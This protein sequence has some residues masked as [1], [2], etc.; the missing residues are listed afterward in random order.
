MT[1]KPPILVQTVDGVTDEPM[2]VLVE[3]NPGIGGIA[4]ETVPGHHETPLAFGEAMEELIA[5]HQRGER[6]DEVFNF[7]AFPMCDAPDIADAIMDAYVS[8][9]ED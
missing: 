3:V 9:A 1:R 7:V 4:V 5:A 6:E 2:T 8:L